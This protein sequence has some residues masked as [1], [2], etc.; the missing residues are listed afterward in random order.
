MA[1]QLIEVEISEKKHRKGK[2]KGEKSEKKVFFIVADATVA[3]RQGRIRFGDT[4]W[5]DSM[6]SGPDCHRP[7]GRR[8]S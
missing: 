7:R 2:K 4:T 8:Q 1:H 5:A 3:T 6:S